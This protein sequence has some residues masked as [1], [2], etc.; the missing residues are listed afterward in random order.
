[1]MALPTFPFCLDLV[2]E[3]NGRGWFISFPDLPGCV[4]DGATPEQAVANGL[5]ALSSWI[6][7]AREF[8][9][10]VPAPGSGGAASGKFSLRAPKS[11][12]AKL[13]KRAQTEGVS[14]NALAVTLLAEGLGRREAGG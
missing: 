10:P 6:R 8:G 14:M 7:T 13:A 4:S 9:D 2:S 11:L 5:D 3:E 12:H 1:M